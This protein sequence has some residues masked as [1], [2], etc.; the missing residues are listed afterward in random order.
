L[1]YDKSKKLR[2]VA[3]PTEKKKF[4]AKVSKSRQ[5]TRG[6]SD[7]NEDFMPT[8]DELEALDNIEVKTF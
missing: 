4:I 7:S 2:V 3:K 8:E 5:A 6:S 1:E